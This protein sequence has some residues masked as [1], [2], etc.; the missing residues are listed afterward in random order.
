MLY[1]H[2]AFTEG[3]MPVCTGCILYNPWAI[4]QTSQHV[5]QW[6]RWL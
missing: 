3:V 6:N 2:P 5:L 4:H 1:L